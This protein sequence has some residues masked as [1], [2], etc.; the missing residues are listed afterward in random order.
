MSF[1]LVVDDSWLVRQSVT[2]M[3]KRSG[4]EVTLAENGRQAL[5]KCE[6]KAFD[7]ILLDLLM[8]DINGLDVLKKLHE[9]GVTTPVIILTA[10]IQLSTQQ[11]C[12]EAGVRDFIIKPP[13]EER[14]INTLNVILSSKEL[15]QL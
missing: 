9:K 6:T 13:N 14:L 12:R 3:L 11:R 8:P 2:T 7:A 10:D 1:I 15:L 5:Q 4:F